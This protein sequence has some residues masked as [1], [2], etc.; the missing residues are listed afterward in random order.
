[1][2]ETFSGVPLD[3]GLAAVEAL[4][5]LVPPGS[6]LTQFALRWTLMW[7]AVSCVIPGA[8]TPAQARENAAAADLSPLSDDAMAGVKRVYDTR[9]REHVEARW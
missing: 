7:D 3:T 2:G 5:P 1:M 8:R 9:I 6:T 4:R